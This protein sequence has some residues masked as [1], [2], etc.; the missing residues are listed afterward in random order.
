MKSIKRRLE[1]DWLYTSLFIAGIALSGS[2][3]DWFPVPNLIGF[4]LMV[5]FSL[6][7]RV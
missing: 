4:S 5:L 1:A 3:G 2:D 7:R 6:L